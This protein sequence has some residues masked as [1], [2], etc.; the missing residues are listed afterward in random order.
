MT[1]YFLLIALFFSLQALDA[2]S[3]EKNSSESEL[4]DSPFSFDNRYTHKSGKK[5]NEIKVFG[6]RSSGTT[7]LI[8]LMTANFPAIQVY[9]NCEH[10]FGYKHFPWWFEFSP[11]R[12][13]L[14]KLNYH[15][16]A[17]TLSHSEKCLFIVIVRNP[18]D[19]LRS[20]Y[21][22]PYHVSKELQGKGFL[23]F[24][25][26]KWRLKDKFQG[27]DGYNPYTRKPFD[28]LLELRS[29]KM[30]NFLILGSKVENFCLVRYEDVAKN[31]KEFVNFI[32]DFYQLKR[33]KKFLPITSYK[34]F[35]TKKYKPK[36]YFSLNQA[37]LN[38]IR[39]SLNWEIENELGYYCQ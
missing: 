29:Y 18:Y 11:T 38:F 15:P 22:T 27:I 20:F 23:H 30:K 32:S 26:S 24:I 33:C 19:W 17:A 25:S 21:K 10:K 16:N 34:G 1:I 2:N 13:D 36:S 35:N 4:T 3:I 39:G 8:A 14:K 7:F 37:T 6:E 9:G 31:P 5:I 12:K 28:N